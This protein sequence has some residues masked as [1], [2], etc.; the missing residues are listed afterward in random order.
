MADRSARYCSVCGEE[1]NMRTRS[2]V[3]GKLLVFLLIVGGLVAIG[4]GWWMSGYNKA[5]RLDEQ[6]KSRW[7]QVDNVLQR[8]YDLIPNL[9][10][11]VKGYATHERELFTQIA[12]SREAYFQA[13]T[14]EDRAEASQGLERYLSRLLVLTETYPELKAQ[15]GFLDLQ[16]QLEGTENRVAVERKRY[17]EAVE[18]L[19]SWRRTILGRFF[20]GWARVNEAKYYEI[21]A[22]VRD[23]PKVDFSGG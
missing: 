3:G 18:A 14:P 22:P 8:R 20:A 2:A 1:V 10:E 9:V 17:N 15:A 23:A 7:A 16:Q 4:A 6:V 12:K 11:T 19:N 21:E 5:I 13:R